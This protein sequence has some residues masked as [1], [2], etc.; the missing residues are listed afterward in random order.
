MNDRAVV[1][2]V[3]TLEAAGKKQAYQ[4]PSLRTFG[5][6]NILTQGTG[7]ANGDSG[8]NMMTTSDRLT[9]ENIV[10]VG[11]HPSGIGLYLFDYK[12]AFR[13]TVDQ[14]RQFGV[15]ADE[16]ETVMPEAVLMHVN[17]YKQVNYAMLGIDLSKRCVH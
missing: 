5:R 15:M 10:Q 14:G 1:Q 16:V 17:G 12:P 9:K 13:T 3:T 11:V 4:P 2:A 6:V 8:Q 7:S